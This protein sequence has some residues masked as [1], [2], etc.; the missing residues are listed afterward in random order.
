M[1]EKLVV[2]VVVAAAFAYAGWSLVP[3]ST[4]LRAARRLSAAAGG[5][6]ATHPLARI[7]QRLEKAAGGGA[8][9]A[10]CDAH[11]PTPAERK[12]GSR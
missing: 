2:A 1:L 5:P 8:G 6:D 7:A 11:E 10:G 9:C 4:R 3:A 12:S